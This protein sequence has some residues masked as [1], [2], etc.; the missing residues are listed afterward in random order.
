MKYVFGLV[1][2]KFFWF[3]YFILNKF[4]WL[5]REMFGMCCFGLKYYINRKYFGCFVKLNMF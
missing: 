4:M 1:I 3:K 2:C 5:Y